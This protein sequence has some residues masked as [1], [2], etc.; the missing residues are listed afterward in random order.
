MVDVKC[1]VLIWTSAQ[2]YDERTS[3][4][5]TSISLTSISFLKNIIVM[6]FVTYWFHIAGYFSASQICDFMLLR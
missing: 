2:K 1:L 5:L 4:S 6:F 3:I